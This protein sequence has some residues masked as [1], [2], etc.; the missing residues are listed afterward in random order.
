MLAMFGHSFWSFYLR[1]NALQFV[2]ALLYAAYRTVQFWQHG[3]RP[4]PPTPRPT[5][6]AHPLWNRT[7]LVRCARAVARRVA[8]EPWP[9][10]PR[11][12]T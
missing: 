4:M 10:P 7:S 11:V 2:A 9:G 3:P 6:R 8:A 5:K 12:D 1:I